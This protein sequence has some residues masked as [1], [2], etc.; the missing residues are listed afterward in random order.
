MEA[1]GV[2][3]VN[4]RPLAA[5]FLLQIDTV[6]TEAMR[7]KT[8]RVSFLMCPF[9]SARDA[10]LDNGARAFACLGLGTQRADSTLLE[11]SFGDGDCVGTRGNPV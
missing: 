5:Q 11:N 10:R 4:A 3:R 1:M 6:R 8:S 7:R 2:A 9:V